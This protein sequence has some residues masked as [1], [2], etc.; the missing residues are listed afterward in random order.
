M[1]IT[2]RAMRLFETLGRLLKAG[3][4]LVFRTWMMELTSGR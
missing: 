3:S 4:S 1:V 2:V